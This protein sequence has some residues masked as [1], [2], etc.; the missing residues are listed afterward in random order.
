MYFR[1]IGKISRQIESLQKYIMWKAD[2]KEIMKVYRES[3]WYCTCQPMKRT[4]C[5]RC[6]IAVHG[7]LRYFCAFVFGKFLK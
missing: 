4:Q 3:G 6:F 1:E 2:K 7:C 5:R